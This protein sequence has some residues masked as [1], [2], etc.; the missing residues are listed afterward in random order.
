MATTPADAAASN[1]EAG[2]LPPYERPEFVAW[3]TSSC[4][5]QNV[6]VTITDPTVIAR[7]ATLLGA[8]HPARSSVQVR[9]TGRTRAI[10]RL[11]DPGVPGAM[12]A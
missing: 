4:E 3:L 5:R 9:H 6:P 12:T 11:R 2:A 1:Y 10:S 8:S 7:I